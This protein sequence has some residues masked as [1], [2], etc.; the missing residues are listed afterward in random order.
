VLRKEK[1]EERGEAGYTDDQ[2]P[3]GVVEQRDIGCKTKNSMR[4]CKISRMIMQS[5]QGNLDV[6]TIP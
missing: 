4:Q 2:V 5:A 3:E 1:E 6:Q